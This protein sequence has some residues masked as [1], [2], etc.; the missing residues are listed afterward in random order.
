MNECE[1]PTFHSIR[2][3][4]IEEEK[5]LFYVALTRAKQRLFISSANADRS[6][7]ALEVSRFMSFFVLMK[8][9][10]SEVYEILWPSQKIYV[11]RG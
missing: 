3:D 11:F 7:R 6:G 1:F 8:R 5:R 9:N 4:N 10:I 2:D